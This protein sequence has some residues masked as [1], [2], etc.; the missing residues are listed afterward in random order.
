[1]VYKRHKHRHVLEQGAH[2]HIRNEEPVKITAWHLKPPVLKSRKWQEMSVPSLSDSMIKACWSPER[3]CRSVF[4][5]TEL[6]CS[7]DPKRS[8]MIKDHFHAQKPNPTSRA[9]SISL[10]TASV[11]SHTAHTA[12]KNYRHAAVISH[13]SF[14]SKCIAFSQIVSSYPEYEECFEFSVLILEIC[15]ICWN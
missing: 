2:T 10:Y 15:V 1:M 3:L 6:S 14:I 12:L 4:L 13:K 9:H 11:Q 8:T 7:K 5:A